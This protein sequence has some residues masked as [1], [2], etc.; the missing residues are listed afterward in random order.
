MY[1]KT[2][3]ALILA[4]VL[5]SKFLIVDAAAIG[6]FSDNDLTIVKPLC[7]KKN[8]P[9]KIDFAKDPSFSKNDASTSQGYVL[10]SLCSP[11]FQFEPVNWEIRIINETVSFHQFFSS[12][13][14]YQYLDNDSPPP[15]LI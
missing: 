6:L 2:Y 7:K 13:L 14:S 15:R 8:S 11:Q 4:F 9:K 3:I 5:T 12:K 1:H 10:I